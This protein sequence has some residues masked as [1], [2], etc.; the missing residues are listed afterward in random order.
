MLLNPNSEIEY[1]A[2]GRVRTKVF[3]DLYLMQQA[4][5]NINNYYKNNLEIPG[6]RKGGNVPES[7]IVNAVGKDVY[8]LAVLEEILKM[9]LKDAFDKL[10]DRVL[11]DTERVETPTKEMVEAVVNKQPMTFAVCAD[12]LPEVKWKTPY[13]DMVVKVNLSENEVSDEEQVEQ[14]IET[15][16]SENAALKMAG[17]RAVKKEDI[18]VVQGTALR[19]DNGEPA[20]NVP[21]TPFKVDLNSS[22][23]PNFVE[24]LVGMQLNEQK[25][26]EIHLPEDWEDQSLRGVTVVFDLKVNEVF[27]KDL[28]ALND[29]YASRLVPNAKTLKEAREYLMQQVQSGKEST[30]ENLF[31]NAMTEAIAENLDLTVPESLIQNI[32]REEYGKQLMELQAQG[33]LSP[34][35]MEKLTADK[36]VQDYITKERST[37]EM[38]ARASIGIAEIISKENLALSDEELEQEVSAAKI[39]IQQENEEEV[40]VD[41]ERLQSVIKERCEAKLV[42]EWIKNN[43]T[44]EYV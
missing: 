26:F 27:E 29:S 35:M 10:G 7:F 43:A 31:Q 19:K 44:V 9:T 5:E 2:D 36:L 13:S 3:V 16:R 21:D 28:P 4:Y 41:M 15:F 34:N 22:S 40:D 8:Y 37:F 20:M 11:A 23:L 39:Q 18:C 24:N 25:Q 32:G 42:F 30:K 33:V 12:L 1:L 14:I 38:L 6:F 17:E